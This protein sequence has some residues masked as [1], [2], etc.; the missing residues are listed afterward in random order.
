VKFEK[1]YGDYVADL[2]KNAVYT[3]F[4]REAPT[5]IGRMKAKPMPLPAATDD[6]LTTTG[7]AAP[8]RIAVPTG[9]PTPTPTPNNR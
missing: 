2:K 5:Q 1:I 8:E 4:V 7:S 3:V 6:E 9:R